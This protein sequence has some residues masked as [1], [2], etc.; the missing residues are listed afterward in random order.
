MIPENKLIYGEL[1]YQIVGILF[2]VYNDLGFGYKEVTFEKAIA[3]QLTKRGLKFQRQIPFQ[4]NY[5]GDKLTKIYLDFLIE[6]KIILE[7]KRGDYFDRRNIKQVNEYLKIT[8]KKL[9]ILANFTPKGVKFLR[10]VNLK[11]ADKPEVYQFEIS[12]LKKKLL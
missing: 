8:N 11:G 2:E 6:D 7:I 1:S 9:A 5:L 12:L 10:I 4:V 3:K